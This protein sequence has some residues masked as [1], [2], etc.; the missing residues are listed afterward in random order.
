MTLALVG[1]DKYLRAEGCTVELLPDW[2]SRGHVGILNPH[3]GLLHHTAG[4]KDLGIVLHGRPDLAGPLAQL[5]LRQNGHVVLVAAGVAW[6]AGKGS[7]LVYDEIVREALVSSDPRFDAADRGLLDDL[8]LANFYYLGIEV[9]NDGHEPLTDEQLDA[10]PRVMAACVRFNKTRGWR[11]AYRWRHHRQHTARKV[12]MAYRGDLWTAANARLKPTKAVAR[13]VNRVTTPKPVPIPAP[14]ST[15]G[16]MLVKFS[17]PEVYEVVGSHLEHVT[18]A[19]FAARGLTW[20]Q[21]KELPDTHP[22]AKLPR[23]KTAA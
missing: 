22:L 14:A 18:A 15:G 8:S 12:D 19:A 7:R 23:V 21:V 3:G 4:H 17:G 13:V 5:Y 11:T 10:L 1:L 9:E 20:S 2:E 16:R 6:H